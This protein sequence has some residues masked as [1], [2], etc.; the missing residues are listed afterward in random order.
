MP[1]R[2]GERRCQQAEHVIS[3]CCVLGVWDAA[4]NE[5]GPHCEYHSL[6]GTSGWYVDPDSRIAE[7]K[8]ERSQ[9]GLP[10]GRVPS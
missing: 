2:A 10:G 7:P 8:A 3:A 9:G 1:G 4:L 5:A 6:G